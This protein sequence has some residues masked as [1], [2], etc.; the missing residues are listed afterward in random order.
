M[1]LSTTHVAI[2]GAGPYGLAAAAHLRAANIET[3]V[4]GEPM[5]FWQQHMPTGMLL[6]SSWDASH[7][8]DP[9]HALTLDAYERDQDIRL[10]KR[11]PLQDFVRY[12]RWFQQ[13]VVPDV[14]ARR[15]TRIESTPRGFEL[16]SDG[17]RILEAKRVVIATGLQNF[18]N[19]PEPFA[20]LPS[21]L[22]SHVSEHCDLKPFAGKSVV[23]VGAGQSALETAVLLHENG[24][25]VE[26]L[27]RAPEVRWLGQ[28]DW[29]RTLP[30]PLNYVFFPP[31]D[32]GPPG[33]NWLV[34]LPD[35]FRRMPRSWQ[36]SLGYRAIRPAVSGW[37]RERAEPLRITAGRNVVA[38]VEQNGKVCLTLDDGSQ[39]CVEHV[40]LGTGY[41][42]DIARMDWLAP[43]LV[44]R[45]QRAGGY[46]LLRA[47]L[48][49]SVPGLH[50]MGAT[51]VWSFGPLMRFV[52]G[53]SYAAPAL[54]RRIA[55]D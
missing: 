16:W 40:M 13:R 11:I 6:R 18:A 49:S 46:P 38:A 28:L 47:G 26:L 5:D 43:E 51:G 3:A 12:G 52:A 42:V 39:R 2:I 35:L 48:E 14:D 54:A 27:A 15:I 24:A 55:R 10:P 41:N 17:S 30:K 37:L 34:A 1:T 4:F 7:I 33:I 9:Q 53:T 44:Q 29:T 31:S 22:V 50:F 21:S 20:A 36:N 23:M 45:V 8:S 19:R 25:Q 32:V